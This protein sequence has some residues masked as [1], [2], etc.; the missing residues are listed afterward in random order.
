MQ[1]LTKTHYYFATHREIEPEIHSYFKDKFGE[2][3]R[4]SFALD[5]MQRLNKSFRTIMSNPTEDTVEVQLHIL[6]G[7]FSDIEESHKAMMTATLRYWRNTMTLEDLQHMDVFNYIYKECQELDVPIRK[8]KGDEIKALEKVSYTLMSESIS[9]I[10]K[11]LYVRLKEQKCISDETGWVTFYDA[12]TGKPLKEIIKKIQ[13][14]RSKNLCVYFICQLL[15][16][17][18]IGDG[19]DLD[20][21]EH[22]I[23]SEE[24]HYWNK[25]ENLFV[26][27]NGKPM[28][29]GDKIKSKMYVLPQH[30]TIIDSILT[31]PYTKKK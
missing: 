30:S 26:D 1:G 23:E 13:W 18:I 5:F 29:Y 21:V 9:D 20:Q 11:G 10:L 31:K 25:L 7:R 6:T 19:F 12:F 15:K 17:R 4:L 14:I 3:A 22:S 24:E 16:I 2:E 28:L 27:T 8:V